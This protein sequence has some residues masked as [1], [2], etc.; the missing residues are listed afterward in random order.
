[1]DIWGDESASFLQMLYV[2]TLIGCT[3]SPQMVKPFLGGSSMDTMISGG[4]SNKSLFSNKLTST[5]LSNVFSYTEMTTE[6]EGTSFESNLKFGFI[7]VGLFLL[8]GML[9]HF[10]HFC[11]SACTVNHISLHGNVLQKELT[12]NRKCDRSLNNS[13]IVQFLTISTIGFAGFL[14]GGLEDM[15]G[16]FL[17]E[18]TVKGLKWAKESG[19]DITSVFW[20]SNCVSRISATIL[21]KWVSVK[22]LM[23]C[24]VAIVLVSS[25]LMTSTATFTSITLWIGIIGTSLGLGSQPGYL[26]VMS[27]NVLTRNELVSTLVTVAIYTGKVATPPVVGYVFQNIDY[28]WFLYVSLIFS[29]VMFLNYGFLMFILYFYGNKLPKK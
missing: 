15:I 22:T 29:F 7:I 5:E 19:A 16:S 26:L 28:S 6:V 20:A 13:R 10:I 9:F 1:M 25:I 8:T 3:I 2:S 27:R 17:V 14:F 12:D 23:G 18:Y 24:C 21:L 4:H 11:T